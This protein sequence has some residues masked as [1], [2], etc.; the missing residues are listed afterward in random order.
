VRLRWTRPALLHLREIV[1]YIERENPS[2][3]RRVVRSIRTQVASLTR[4]PDIGRIGRV[5]GTREL[6]MTRLPW[7]VA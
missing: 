5:A 1:E 2:A 4:H 3:A 7:V 6:V